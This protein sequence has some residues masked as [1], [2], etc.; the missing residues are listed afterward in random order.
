M[1]LRCDDAAFGVVG[2]A[3]LAPAH[4]EAI[5][6]AAV[7]DEGNGLGR[8]AERDRQGAGGERIERAGMAGALG[9]EQPLHDAH[10]VGRGHADRLVEHDP[11]VHVALVALAVFWRVSALIL[12]SAAQR[13]V[14]RLRHQ[15]GD[16]DSSN[17][18]RSLAVLVV[19]DRASLPASA[20]A[21]RCA[22]PRRT[23]RRRGS[24]CRAR[25]SG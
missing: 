15:E 13:L 18:V 17:R 20:A 10:R 1:S 4:G 22:R 8:F 6:L 7:H 25:I 23:A 21:C 16:A 12:A 24:G 5:E 3:L 9:P 2:V 19:S 11:A 14:R